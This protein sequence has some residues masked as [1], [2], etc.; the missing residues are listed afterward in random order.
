MRSVF[1]CATG[2]HEL[3]ELGAAEQQALAD[4][5]LARVAMRAEALAAVEGPRA[6]D[7]EIVRA[8]AANDPAFA[9]LARLVGIDPVGNV[10]VG[11]DEVT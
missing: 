7:L 9:A 4:A 1:D 10:V 3:V 6:A 8:A 2:R 5:Q 11:V